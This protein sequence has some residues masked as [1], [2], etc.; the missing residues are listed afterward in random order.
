VVER[1]I[2]DSA[3]ILGGH[4]SSLMTAAMATDL[5]L[6]SP[7]AVPTH[8]H[9][10]QRMPTAR[11][12]AEHQQRAQDAPGWLTATVITASSRWPPNKH[13]SAAATEPKPYRKVLGAHKGDILHALAPHR[14]CHAAVAL[15]RGLRV[16]NKRSPP[17]H[18]GGSH[19]WP[20][21]L[22]ASWPAGRPSAWL[23]PTLAASA[24]RCALVT[25]RSMAVR[26]PRS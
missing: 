22:A 7:R 1:R 11:C 14:R 10:R 21:R 8:P 20:H 12:T 16:Q 6:Y 3:E 4:E 24:Q 5:P 15:R 19:P 2:L 9:G 18:G 23:P 17:A 25:W 13:G 26:R